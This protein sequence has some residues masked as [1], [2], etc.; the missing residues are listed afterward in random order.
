[1]SRGSNYAERS[2][3]RDLVTHI[4]IMESSRG[5]PF[6]KVL[7]NGKK[8]RKMSLEELQVVAKNEHANSVHNWKK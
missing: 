3:K 8:Y 2:Q 1:M 4:Q 6:E 7:S 5:V